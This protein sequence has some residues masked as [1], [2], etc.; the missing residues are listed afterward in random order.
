MRSLLIKDIKDPLLKWQT[1]D[2][3]NGNIV[4][5]CRIM[6]TALFGSKT[7]LF[8]IQVIISKDGLSTEASTN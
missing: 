2:P 3:D 8:F 1:V 7:G 6:P 4:V 5:I